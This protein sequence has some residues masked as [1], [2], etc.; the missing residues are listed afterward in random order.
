MSVESL[1]SSLGLQEKR[2]AIVPEEHTS[3][4]QLIDGLNM[5]SKAVIACKHVLKSPSLTH[6]SQTIRQSPSV[7]FVSPLL[8]HG[9]K[10]SGIIGH[11]L[12]G[13]AEAELDRVVASVIWVV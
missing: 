8:D 12:I 4:R 3:I 7:S 9:F 5:S 1:T 6:I 10:S 11:E 13:L 2:V